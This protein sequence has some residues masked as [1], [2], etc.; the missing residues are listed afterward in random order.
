MVGAV[1]AASAPLTNRATGDVGVFYVAEFSKVFLA[2]ITGSGLMQVLA[3]KAARRDADLPAAAC[4]P[5]PGLRSSLSAVQ[6]R[7]FEV[8]VALDAVHGLV[9]NLALVA[10]AHEGL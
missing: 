1:V 9:A 5:W 4:C 6:A 2:A 10:Q 3:L 7:L 8:E